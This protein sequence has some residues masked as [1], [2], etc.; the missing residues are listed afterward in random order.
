MKAQRK[1]VGTSNEK[2]TLSKFDQSDEARDDSD[3]VN[4]KKP[5]ADVVSGESLDVDNED[6]IQTRCGGETR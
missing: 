5:V 2:R 4:K 6:S 1:H 3:Q